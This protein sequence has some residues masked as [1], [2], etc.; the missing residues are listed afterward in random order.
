LKSNIEEEPIDDWPNFSGIA[1]ISIPECIIDFYKCKKY[2]QMEN[3]IKNLSKYYNSSYLK[4]YPI[5]MYNDNDQIEQSLDRL[6]PPELKNFLPIKT[7]GDGNCLFNAVSIILNKNENLSKELK[8]FTVQ[9][10]FQNEN[11]FRQQFSTRG[12]N[13]FKSFQDAV[14]N[15]ALMHRFQD[16][17]GITA[18]AQAIDRPLWIFETK[19]SF[20][21]KTPY[22]SE[23]RLPVILFLNDNHFTALISKSMHMQLPKVPDYK[24]FPK[25]SSIFKKLFKRK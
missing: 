4:K 25:Q 11:Y 18:L 7:K 15:V 6:L 16:S 10:I 22:I 1:K 13:N 17:F 14:E 5:S 8:F 9:M 12:S 21:Y 20:E 3:Y 2:F 24:L 19:K 23:G